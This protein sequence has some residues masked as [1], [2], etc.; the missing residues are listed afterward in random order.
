MVLLE[1]FLLVALVALVAFFY[2]TPGAAQER[3]SSNVFFPVPF[4][5]VGFWQNGFFTIFIFGPPDFFADR[6]AG[7]FLP[8]FCVGYTGG[9]AKQVPFV[10]LAF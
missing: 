3:T 4:C 8:H 1:G 7:C 5:R 6:F 10:K 9:R 2:S